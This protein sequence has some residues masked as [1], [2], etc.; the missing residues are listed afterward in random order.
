M[1]EGGGEREKV[2]PPGFK[3]PERELLTLAV[4]TV[5][6]A[7]EIISLSLSFSLCIGIAK[8]LEIKRK[9]K[10]R[11]GGEEEASQRQASTSL[12]GDPLKKANNCDKKKSSAFHKLRSRG[13]FSARAR[14]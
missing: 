1:M 6:R 2:K 11:G 3:A 5:F 13:A 8:W 14:I 12:S 4:Q 10:A 9:R 7:R